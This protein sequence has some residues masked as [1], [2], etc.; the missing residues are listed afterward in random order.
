MKN[1]LPFERQTASLTTNL[2]NL[3]IKSGMKAFQRN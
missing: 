2:K 3:F 1:G